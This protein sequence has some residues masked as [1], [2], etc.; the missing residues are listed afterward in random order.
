MGAIYLIRHGQASFGSSNYDQLSELGHAQA[1]RLGQSLQT[2]LPKVDAVVSGSMQRHQATAA[3]CLDTMGLNLPVAEQVGFNEF[4]H[5]QVIERMEP[6]YTDKLVMMSDM[7]ATGDPRRAFQQFFQQAVARWVAGQH[8]ADYTESWRAFQQRCHDAVD[9]IVAQTGP[10]GTSLV[11]T[12]GGVIS[13]VC[14]RLLNIPDEHAFTLNWT[15]ANAGVTKLIV[16]KQGV[17]LSTVNEHSHFE[18]DNAKLLSYR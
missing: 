11:F 15:L 13:A 12:S 8:D 1:R 17:H 10:S 3:S 4:D 5:E 2:R 9:A 18:G 16:G 14:Q 6:R 7:A